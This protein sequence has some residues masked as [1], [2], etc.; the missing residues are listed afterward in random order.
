VTEI[1]FTLPDAEHRRFRDCRYATVQRLG[2][3]ELTNDEFLSMLLDV[4]Q[5][6]VD[7]EGLEPRGD[8]FADEQLVA[9]G[10]GHVLI[11]PANTRSDHV[12]HHPDPDDPDTPRCKATRGGTEA[13][14][15]ARRA[16]E[17]LDDRYR[18]CAYCDPD[19]EQT[20]NSDDMQ[21]YRTL[22]EADDLE[23]LRA[24]GGT[25]YR[26]HKGVMSAVDVDR[27]DWAL[28]IAVGDE[29]AFEA[30]PDG[31]IRTARVIGF[32][33]HDGEHH[34]RPVI[35]PDAELRQCFADDPDQ[36]VITQDYYVSE[37]DDAE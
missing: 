30:P 2:A 8:R 23:D 26:Q 29:I 7:R 34:G 12:Y 6:H 35:L 4:W 11:R 9:D 15:Y 24:D 19:W 31:E 3:D 1:N 37:V 33:S 5:L 10:A 17:A 28:D 13:R 25:T 36:I 14:R 20:R 32:S 18:L 21:H 22:A 27:P 16:P